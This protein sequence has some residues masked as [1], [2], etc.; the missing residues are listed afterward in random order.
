MPGQ[1]NNKGGG[2][3]GYHHELVVKQAYEIVQASLK[4]TDKVINPKERFYA[5][6]ELVKKA[7]PNNFDFGEKTLEILFDGIFNVETTQKTERDN[8]VSGKVQDNTGG[9]PE[10]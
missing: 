8:S 1:I 10:R 7:I 3:K 5:A 4:K 2:R 6:L 9:P